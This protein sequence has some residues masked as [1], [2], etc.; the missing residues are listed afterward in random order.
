MDHLALID[1]LPSSIYAKDVESNNYKL[2][3]LFADQANEIENT[4]VSVFDLENLSGVNLDKLGV[5]NGTPRNSFG[6]ADYKVELLTPKSLDIVTL[7]AI[8]EAL[9]LYGAGIS[10]T[11]LHSPR[12]YDL[13]L[14]D[15]NLL[16]D[17]TKN[18]STDPTPRV[19]FTLDGNRFLD[20]N[21]PLEPYFIRFGFLAEITVGIHARWEKIYSFLKNLVAGVSVYFQPLV[22]IDRAT[23]G[24]MDTD[25]LTSL[26]GNGFLD[27]NGMFAMLTLTLW[28]NGSKILTLH[29][30]N[31]F[32]ERV[33]RYFILADTTDNFDKIQLENA[34]IA[35]WSLERVFSSN[36]MQTYVFDLDL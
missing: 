4:I 36:H 9:S 20:G 12:K 35:F 6:D 15:G 21:E 18:I 24:I 7:P 31:V 27:G 29:E 17:G 30:S 28:K 8:Y 3:K 14:L 2:W 10:I 16:L 5:L 19:I 32:D 25:I 22:V 1:K 23:E 26:D 33:G 11:E 34:G 13:T